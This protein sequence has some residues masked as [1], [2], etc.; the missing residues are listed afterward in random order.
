M[1]KDSRILSDCLQKWARHFILLRMRT[2][3]LKW[4]QWQLGAWEP[5]PGIRSLRT[6]KGRIESSSPGSADQ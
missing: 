1:L 3:R 5:K 6:C 4:F 2:V